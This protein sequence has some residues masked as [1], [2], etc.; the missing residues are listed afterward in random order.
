MTLRWKRAPRETGLRSVGAGPYRS[1]WLQ[2]NGVRYACVSPSGGDWRKPLQGWY[3]TAGWDS[4]IPGISTCDQLCA[5]EEEAKAAALQ[6]VRNA[7][8]TQPTKDASN[9]SGTK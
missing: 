4:D 1:S 3:W 5:T 6:Y 7:I 8:K 9:A 2:E